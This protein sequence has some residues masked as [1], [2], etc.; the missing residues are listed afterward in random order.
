MTGLVLALDQGT[1]SSGALL[2]DPSLAQRIRAARIGD[3][4]GNAERS[5]LFYELTAFVGF[6]T[7]YISME[8]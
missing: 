1:T 6:N 7:H 5:R 3:D 4:D 8:F 2:F